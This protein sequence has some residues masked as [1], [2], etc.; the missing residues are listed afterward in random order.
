MCIQE[1]RFLTLIFAFA[2]AFI[3]AVY[4]MLLLQIKEEQK[5]LKRKQINQEKEYHSKQF[6]VKIQNFRY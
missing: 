5:K 3:G 1:I 4:C 2:G 6:I